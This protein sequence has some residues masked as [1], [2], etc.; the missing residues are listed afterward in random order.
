MPLAPRLLLRFAAA[1]PTL[2]PAVTWFHG[3]ALRLALEREDVFSLRSAKSP[4]QLAVLLRLARRRRRVVELGTA[5][6]WTAA[7]LALADRRRGVISYD[8]VVRAERER[9]LGLLGATTRAR[10]VLLAARGEEAAR[11]EPVD[12]LFI[13]SSH[14]RAA[15]LAEWHAWRP[16]LAPGALVVFDDYGHPEFPGVAE[17]IAELGLGG[18]AQAGMFVWRAPE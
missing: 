3:R 11:T 7:A 1:A 10:V 14:E 16:R 2:P 17:A 4:R 12:L 18:R 9:Y 6:G 8:P 13:D 5:T 15:T